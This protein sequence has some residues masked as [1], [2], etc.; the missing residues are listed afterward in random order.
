MALRFHL[1]E[2]VANAIA[3]ALRRRGIDVSTTFEAGLLGAEDRTHIEFAKAQGRVIHTHDS[4]FLALAESG[5]DH[6]GIAFCAPGARTIRQVIEILVLMD[7]CL[8]PEE[9]RNRIEFI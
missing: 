7:A 3:T 8:T 4:D 9:M 6:A 1:D 2:H 5:V